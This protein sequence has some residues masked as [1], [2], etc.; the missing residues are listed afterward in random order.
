MAGWIALILV[1]AAF[2]EFPALIAMPVL[3]VRFFLLWEA[4]RDYRD[5]CFAIDGGAVLERFLRKQ[6]RYGQVTLQRWREI[7]QPG[8]DYGLPW[9][10]GERLLL[11]TFGEKALG[12]AHRIWRAMTNVTAWPFIALADLLAVQGTKA[13]LAKLRAF[14]GECRER[15][16]LFPVRYAA[17]GSRKRL[18]ER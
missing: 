10:E 11:P 14:T 15:G 3:A 12:L 8:P 13:L 6:R 17:D 16:S 18:L 4:V 1:I 9:H 7:V 2:E 5:I